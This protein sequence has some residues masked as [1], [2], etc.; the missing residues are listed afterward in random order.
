MDRVR[1]EN[2]ASQLNDGDSAGTREGDAVRDG[3]IARKETDRW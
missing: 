1:K 3:E 2:R